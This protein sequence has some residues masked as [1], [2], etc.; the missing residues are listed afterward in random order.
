MREPEP[1]APVPLEALA[2]PEGAAEPAPP[3]E[4]AVRVLRDAA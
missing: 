1:E 4:V 2:A 3:S